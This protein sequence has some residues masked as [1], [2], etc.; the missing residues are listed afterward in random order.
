MTAKLTSAQQRALD[1][2]RAHHGTV[3]SGDGFSV[4]TVRALERAGLCTVTTRLAADRILG[5]LR[6][7]VFE[8]QLTDAGWGE[9]ERTTAPTGPLVEPTPEDELR[10]GDIVESVYT[11][12]RAT[13]LGASALGDYATRHVGGAV[14][15]SPAGCYR[16][17]SRPEPEAPADE[18]PAD[19]P[20]PE[21]P[22]FVRGANGRFEAGQRVTFRAVDG[23]LMSGEIASVD[24]ADRTVTFLADTRQVAPASR[25]I[26]GMPNRPG[27]ARAITPPEEW[28]VDADSR[29][30]KHS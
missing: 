27:P 23:Y 17:V 28:T 20:A 11:L 13:W 15:R 1:Y 16:F 3:H 6:T 19:E 10:E 26:K 7:R 8:A 30:L 25:P 4:T 21:E 18:A 22:A 24:R 12:G 14:F 5:S 9:H 29:Q 2:M